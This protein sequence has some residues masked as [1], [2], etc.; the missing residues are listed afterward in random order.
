MPIIVANSVMRCNRFQ[1]KLIV[2]RLLYSGSGIPSPVMSHL[3]LVALVRVLC[4]PILHELAT[5]GLVTLKSI[6]VLL[7]MSLLY[8]PLPKVA[9]KIR[10]SLGR[11][12]SI[13]VRT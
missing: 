6:L 8:K 2:L 7:N 13:S 5:F 12:F 3:G 4:K 10:L 1:Q 9:A 11:I